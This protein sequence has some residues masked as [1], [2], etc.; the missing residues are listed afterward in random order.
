MRFY[1]LTSRWLT[2]FLA[3][4]LL[5]AQLH[6]CADFAPDSSGSHICQ[7]CAT[8]SHAVVV[9]APIVQPT[10]MVCRFASRCSQAAKPFAIVVAGF[11]SRLVLG[12]FIHPVLYEVAAREGDRLQV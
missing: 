12:F 10:S 5:G 11:I 7:F 9:P 4:L 6:F 8:A 2:V 1:S 3:F